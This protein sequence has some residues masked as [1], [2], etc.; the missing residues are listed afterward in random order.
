MADLFSEPLSYWKL[1]AQE[2][3][4][5]TAFKTSYCTLNWRQVDEVVGV[6]KHQL[7][8]QG[9]TR[10]DVLTIVGKN[11][12]EVVMVYIAA[13]ELG[14]VCAFT[15]PQPNTSLKHKLDTLYPPSNQPCIFYS[16]HSKSRGSEPE[17]SGIR[18]IEVSPLQ[19]ALMEGE[20]IE[21]VERQDQ[22]RLSSI[23]FTSGSTGNPKAVA[24][25]L[26]QHL[27]SA[28][29]LLN[30]IKYEPSGC[31]LLSLPIYHVSGLAIVHRW[32]LAGASLKVG[33][34]ELA[35]D[36]T[37]CTHASLVPTQLHRL[38]ESNQSL[39]LTHV[40]L[41]GSHIPVKLAQQAQG[42]GIETWLGYGMTEAAST[43]TAKMVD[44]TNTTGALL[45]YR[46]IKIDQGRIFISGD[47]LASGYYFQ[48][49]LTPLR[50]VEGWFDSKD[51]GN[52]V[53][54]ELQIVGRVDNQFISGGENIHCEEI[55]RVLNAHP[56]VTQA[57]IIPVDDEEFGQRPVAII[58]T[59]RKIAL[60]D[61]HSF[62]DGKLERFKWPIDYYELPQALM[63]TGIK[64]SRKA[65]KD[66]LNE[67]EVQT[68]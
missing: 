7:S 36:A 30:A 52:W 8:M 44:G 68:R 11:S 18:N 21:R 22:S 4:T 38:I 46:E 67:K 45:L 60:P 51:L 31:W 15:M 63:N 5:Q 66:W 48:G 62:L 58:Q 57:Y 53:D 42:M 20:R 56:A 35:L 41:G 6:Y 32:L 49:K 29:G 59:S 17:L 1:W 27:F 39:S 55:E 40:L 12:P 2:R 50:N 16:H 9:L 13:L 47:T 25:N 54:G 19:D 24:Y 26:E 64:V 37:G 28:K 61:Y 10:N 43:V 3:P 34:G 23:I 33:S 65:L 14:V